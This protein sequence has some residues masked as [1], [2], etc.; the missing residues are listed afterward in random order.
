MTFWQWLYVVVLLAGIFYCV[1]RA[2]IGTYFKA[3]E[4]YVNRL[5]DKLKGASNGKGE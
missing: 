4:S 3:K 5:V 1:S 2:V